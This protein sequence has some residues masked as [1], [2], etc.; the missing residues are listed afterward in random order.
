LNLKI[1]KPKNKILF[2]SAILFLAATGILMPLQFID[3]S[4][5]G[6]FIERP[7]TSIIFSII[8]AI[9]GAASYIAIT[10]LGW[11]GGL[12]DRV[13]SPD[14][15]TLSLTNS[16][17]VKQ[18][19][20]I[21]RN[22]A[23]MIFMLIMLVIAF[24]VILRVDVGGINIKRTLPKLIFVAFFINFSRIIAGVIIDAGQIVMVTFTNGV[25]PE[26]SLAMFLYNHMK[27]G[28][29]FASPSYLETVSNGYTEELTAIA[30]MFFNAA[31]PFIAA[32]AFFILAI[33]LIIRIVIL[34]ILVILAPLAWL[35]YI[36]PNT[37]TYWKQWWSLFLQYTF[38]G[39]TVGFFMYL[40]TQM[41]ANLSAYEQFTKQVSNNITTGSGFLADTSNLLQYLT[42][43]IMLYVSIIAAKK[44]NSM[45]VNIAFKVLNTAK[46]KAYQWGVKTP[47]ATSG[48][49]G[50]VGAKID[51]WR[52]TGWL[53]MITPSK[54]AIREKE[55]SWAARFGVKGV[56]EEQEAKDIRGQ[57]EKLK[58]TTS[59]DAL[60]SIIMT[61]K[62]SEAKAAAILL[63]E[64]EDI[65]D[66][67][68]FNLALNILQEK[69]LKTGKTIDTV[70]SK[71]FV[72]MAGEKRLDLVLNYKT[73]EKVREAKA[74]K[75]EITP[76]EAFQKVWEESN[77]SLDK[78][79]Q[80]DISF[81]KDPRIRKQMVKDGIDTRDI[82]QISR[83][84]NEAM[85]KELLTIAHE[86]QKNN[87]QKQQNYDQGAGI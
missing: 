43:T 2:R 58:D 42:I 54:E 76:E 6:D 83:S 4:L 64:R 28:S 36:L 21:T 16:Y 87:Y 74:R 44:T 27:A 53:K 70:R 57:L 1:L 81:I 10:F 38:F 32:L 9:G 47:L 39:A 40:S 31:F 5:V 24:S 37:E 45:G 77:I 25:A 75:E 30:T 80:Q 85:K 22:F 61:K 86:T 14:F 59:S 73:E 84:V 68:E 79:S 17:F 15:N 60:R 51:E 65:K 33:I 48:I 62:G 56:K 50:G 52:T 72:K 19:W 78:I 20:T 23:N 69:D 82:K 34:W 7:L 55:Q 66:K 71:N 18:G 63:G 26:G 29:M 41:A 46:Q 13:L 12:F 3:A 35:A 11:T 8:Y 67:K 49:A